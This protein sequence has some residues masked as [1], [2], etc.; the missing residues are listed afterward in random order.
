MSH[1]KLLVKALSQAKPGQLLKIRSLISGMNQT[2]YGA[3]IFYSDRA[4]KQFDEGN[5][6]H[7]EVQRALVL[8]GDA[9]L[10]NILG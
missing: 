1:E 5:Y 2:A 10:A 6:A 9:R 4:L 7:W 3:L 8:I